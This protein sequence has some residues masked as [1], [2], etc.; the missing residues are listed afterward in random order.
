MAT[1]FRKWLA[2]YLILSIVSIGSLPLPAAALL[3]P[4]RLP[5]GPEQTEQARHTQTLLEAQMISQ[6]LLEIGLKPHEAQGRLAGLSDEQIH[7]LA[8]QLDVLEPG[9]G[10]WI[11]IAVL[12]GIALVVLLVFGV[13]AG[14]TEAIF[15]H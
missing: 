12:G 1:W 4:E 9:G 6:R 3:I 8:Q 10:H 11:L 14:T 15:G 13:T 5:G 2:L 7:S